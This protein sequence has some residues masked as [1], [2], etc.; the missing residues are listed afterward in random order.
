MTVDASSRIIRP[1]PPLD[2]VDMQGLDRLTDAAQTNRLHLDAS[3]DVALSDASNGMDIP[4]RYFD[5]SVTKSTS[6][7]ANGPIKSTGIG[8]AKPRRLNSFAGSKSEGAR[9]SHGHQARLRN[10]SR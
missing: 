2:E 5:G 3:T 10:R 8:A 6:I 4:H 9:S 1:S 7:E